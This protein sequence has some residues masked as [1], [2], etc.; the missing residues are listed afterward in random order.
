MVIQN[1]VFPDEFCPEE[2]IYFHTDGKTDA[3]N[4][5]VLLK[6]GEYFSTFAYMNV[7]DAGFWRTYTDV[8][9]ITLRLFTVGKGS[10]KIYI[11]KENETELFKELEFS[12]GQM[13][14]DLSSIED[15]LIYFSLTAK[16][17]SCF[18]RA[19]YSSEIRQ[20]NEVRIAAAAA[21]ISG[22]LENVLAALEESSFFEKEKALYGA[23][24]VYSEEGEKEP[25]LFDT[26]LSRIREDRGE[27][28]CTHVLFLT[29]EGEFRIE[30][31]YRLYAFLSMVK[32]EYK[33][34]PVSATVLCGSARNVIHTSKE[35]WNHSEIIH[36]DEGKDISSGVNILTRESLTED[37][38]EG[39]SYALWRLCAYPAGYAL[40]NRPY[41]FYG[42]E[43]SA[44]YGL[45]CGKEPAELKGFE[46]FG[47]AF[48]KEKSP[49]D[50]YYEVRNGLITDMMESYETDV[51]PVL[52]RWNKKYKLYKSAGAAKERYCCALALRH[53]SKPGLC[54]KN[55]GKAP[56]G[57]FR[58]LKRK[59]LLKPAA[60]LLKGFSVIYIY[61]GYSFF[62]DR[63]IRIRREQRWQ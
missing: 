31:L 59:R 34:S 13:D 1:I 41:P 23:L 38:S 21:G 42:G 51:F 14:T 57:S 7:L 46:A 25:P 53:A 17:P 9:D 3:K 56:A 60:V 15:G 39:G 19:F 48:E 29:D 28:P 50:I 55:S 16:E 8:R 6:E 32:E 54:R 35:V 24:K 33:D 2:S 44:E 49:E 4:G 27:F 18:L 62:R 58:I 26:L 36:K 37:A 20:P 45:R 40:E 61:I 5:T 52:G 30:G 12:A 47:G 10:L 11:K 63:Y 43:G 22:R